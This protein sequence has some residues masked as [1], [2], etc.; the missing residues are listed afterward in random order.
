MPCAFKHRYRLDT[1]CKFAAIRLPPD[2]YLRLRSS[3]AVFYPGYTLSA[4]DPAANATPRQ[5]S[6]GPGD[7]VAQA[8]QAR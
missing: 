1:A 6:L 7:S 2:F 4:S 5:L 3:F 8:R